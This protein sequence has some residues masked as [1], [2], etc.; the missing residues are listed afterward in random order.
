MVV[1]DEAA[2]VRGHRQHFRRQWQLVPR[3]I[4][5]GGRRSRSQRTGSNAPPSLLLLRGCERA[6][7]L[8]RGNILSFQLPLENAVQYFQHFT[9]KDSSVV[10]HRALLQTLRPSRNRP[11]IDVL[12]SS[13]LIASFCARIPALSCCAPQ[14]PNLPRSDNPQLQGAEYSSHD[15]D[16]S[17][18]SPGSSPGSDKVGHPQ[19]HGRHL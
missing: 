8:L 2:R 7:G 17:L 9:A 4:L 6:I 18:R 3:A 19:S 16:R 13:H 5:A 11:A 10:T 14:S 12:L 15:D 1:D